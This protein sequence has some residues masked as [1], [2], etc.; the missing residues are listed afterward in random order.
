ML[1][2]TAITYHTVLRILQAITFNHAFAYLIEAFSVPQKH[3]IV[4][5]VPKINLDLLVLQKLDLLCLAASHYL[6]VSKFE[7]EVLANAH[8]L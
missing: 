2:T 3:A 1:S 7:K 6:S 5:M 4:F 8:H